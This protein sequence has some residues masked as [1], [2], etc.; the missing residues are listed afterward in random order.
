[1]KE[2]RYYLDS[3]AIVKRYIEE[4]NSDIVSEIYRE[5]YKGISK[6]SFSIWNV[7][8]VL[9][10]LD[11]AKRIGALD[12]K[13]YEIAR[14]NFLAE[15]LRMKKLRL[16]E[17]V[18]LFNS[19][20]VQCWDLVEKYHVYQADALQLVSARVSKADLF[21]TADKKLHEIAIKE[22]LDSKLV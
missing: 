4:E 2:T 12:E 17:L 22:K 11:R 9:G 6:I 18:N 10:V 15:L 20:I 16:I 8:E 14:N 7:G 21:Y 19:I 1:M 3:S 13:D 5:A